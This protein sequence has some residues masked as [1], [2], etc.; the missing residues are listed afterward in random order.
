M[1]TSAGGAS[2]PVPAPPLAWPAPSGGQSGETHQLDVVVTLRAAGPLG[3]EL[4]PDDPRFLAVAGLVAG[5]QC[6]A[7]LAQQGF[8]AHDVAGARLVSVDG[9]D[10]RNDG[11]CR[12][13]PRRRRSASPRRRR[14]STAT[15]TRRRPSNRARRCTPCSTASRFPRSS[16]TGSRRPRA[17][18]SGCC[19]RRMRASKPAPARTSRRPASRARR[20]SA[21]SRADGMG[22]RLARKIRWAAVWTAELG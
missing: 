6:A 8:S 4:D 15:T 21:T 22:N 14:R 2:P 10:A 1:D 13:G 18:R 7:A 3:L 17:T 5:G 11:D 20:P 19:A 16:S 9:A 12:G